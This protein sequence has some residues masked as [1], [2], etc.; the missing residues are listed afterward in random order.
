MKFV[1]TGLPRSRTAWFAGYFT[2]GD[3][4]CVHEAAFYDK[5][6]DLPFENIGTADSGYLNEPEWAEAFAPDKV[7]VVHRPL[8]EVIRS[9]DIIGITNV[10]DKMADLQV[11][12]NEVVG[13][14]V[15]FYDIGLKDIHEYLGLPGYNKERA[16]LFM[17]LNIQHQ[18][19]RQ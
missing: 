5:D 16:D 17:H 1:I 2:Q 13:L 14:H 12:L 6:M 7:V 8:K 18:N 9:L 19:W 15:D 4:I 3:T 11:R 10:D